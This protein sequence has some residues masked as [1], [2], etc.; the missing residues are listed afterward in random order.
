MRHARMYTR[1]HAH[2]HARVYF[3]SYHVG[4]GE[5]GERTYVRECAYAHVRVRPDAPVCARVRAMPA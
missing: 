1:V 4:T 3:P 5:A 2:A